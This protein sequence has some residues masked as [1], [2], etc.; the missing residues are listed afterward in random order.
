MPNNSEVTEDL[1]ERAG[2]RDGSALTRLLERHRARLRRMVAARMDH[3]LS[4][5]VDPS[6]VVQ[7]ALFDGSRK[8][9]EYVRDRPLPFYHWLRRLAQLR[10][11]WWY[12]FHLRSSKR[13][14]ARER[15]PGP[16][17]SSQSASRLVDR[18]LDTG[19]SPSTH[20]LRNEERERV[21]VALDHLSQRDREI[22]E[23]R[24]LEDLSF[25]EIAARLGI[26]QS[27]AKL[28]HFRALRRIR[29]VLDV[30]GAESGA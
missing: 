20:A 3:R 24:Y 28:R 29:V 13:S 27:A 25:P 15:P 30:P 26:G 5:R 8:I 18:I 23:Q 21:L 4:A 1:L 2:R 16:P 10:L 6:D 12:R 17:F 19:P 7:E 14:V 9:P 22:L 11:V